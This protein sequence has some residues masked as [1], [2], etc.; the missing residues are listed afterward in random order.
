MQNRSIEHVQ[1]AHLGGGHSDDELF[2]GNFYKQ[3][4]F[5]RPERL[6]SDDVDDAAAADAQ[7]LP[8]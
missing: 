7:I 4:S 2:A 8:A 1:F 5:F 6:V 3:Y